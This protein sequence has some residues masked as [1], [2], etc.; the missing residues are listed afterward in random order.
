VCRYLDDKFLYG[1]KANAL[2]RTSAAIPEE[3]M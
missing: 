2:N 3:P 1:I